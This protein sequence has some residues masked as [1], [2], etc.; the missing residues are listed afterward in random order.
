[1]D[2]QSSNTTMELVTFEY[3]KPTLSL[4]KTEAACIGENVECTL[5][6][7]PA[8]LTSHWRKVRLCPLSQL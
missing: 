7:T 5:D 1:M 8:D 4:I 3:Q 6:I 2:T